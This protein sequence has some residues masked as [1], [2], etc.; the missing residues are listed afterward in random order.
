[1]MP[2]YDARGYRAIR[3]GTPIAATEYRGPQGRTVQMGGEGPLTETE[4]AQWCAAI[5][6]ADEGSGQ[7]G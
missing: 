4:L 3:Q 6:A 5:D 2:H 1:M 7:H